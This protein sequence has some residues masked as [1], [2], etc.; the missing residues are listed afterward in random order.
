[1][2]LFLIV[3]IALS[4]IRAVGQNCNPNIAVTVRVCNSNYPKDTLC[5]RCYDCSPRLAASD[6]NFSIVSFK[7]IA[8]GEGFDGNIEEI[9]NTGAAFNEARRILVKVRPGSNIEFSC[10]KAKYKNENIS[11][12]LQPLILALK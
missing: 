12:I 1:M 9:I 11:Y 2:R 10:I 4:C 5:P 8:D 7:V 3:C 6:S